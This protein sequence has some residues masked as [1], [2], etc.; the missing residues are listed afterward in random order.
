[1]NQESFVCMDIL[2]MTYF[3]TSIIM[4]D[5]QTCDMCQIRQMMSALPQ[6][7]ALASCEFYV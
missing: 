4:P 2:Y 3:L 1:M 5:P 6:T 7:D